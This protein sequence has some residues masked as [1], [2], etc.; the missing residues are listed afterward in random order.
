M[1][2]CAKGREMSGSTRGAR[3]V[4]TAG[5]VPQHKVVS[6]RHSDTGNAQS[7]PGGGC[8]TQRDISDNQIRARETDPR[9]TVTRVEVAD[10]NQIYIRIS[11]ESQT[12]LT[13]EVLA[14]IPHI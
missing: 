5:E 1:D 8:S 7:G 12:P 3:T 6:D 13:P 4:V 2:R 10:F 9:I 11:R 14:M